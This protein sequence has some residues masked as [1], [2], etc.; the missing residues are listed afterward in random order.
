MNRAYYSDTIANFNITQIEAII[1]LMTLASKYSN[2]PLQ[3]DAWVEEIKI[4]KVY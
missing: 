4:Y 2:E 3:K 1:G